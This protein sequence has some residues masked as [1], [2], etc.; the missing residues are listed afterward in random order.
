MVKTIVIVE[1]NALNMKLFDEVLRAYGYCTV[2]SPD[3]ED[4]VEIVHDHS[5]DLIVMDVQLPNRSGL[6]LSKMLKSDAR[7]KH[8]P[9]LAVTAFAAQLNERQLEEAGCDH[10]ISKPI[11]IPEF[12][13]I[14]ASY[15]S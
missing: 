1:D 12:L 13:S 4:I 10:C 9:V 6:E 15:L 7:L 2:L 14:V 3:G 8:L 5:A 11:S